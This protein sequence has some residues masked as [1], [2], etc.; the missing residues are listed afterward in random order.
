MPNKP[1]GL[2]VPL[3]KGDVYVVN[4]DPTVGAETR[5]LRPA[6][7]IQ[8]NVGNQYSPV[9]T[10]APVSNAKLLAKPIPVLVFLR[11]GEGGLKQDSY[12]HCEQIR[13]VDKSRLL[14]KCGSLPASRISEVNQAI[15]ISTAYLSVPH[16]SCKRGTHHETVQPP[17]S[18]P[19]IY[20][21]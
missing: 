15:K 14:E 8:N 9:T 2:V 7:I 3:L 1:S 17:G 13:T 20:R 12:V 5:K 4:L 19:H 11:A 10:V 18:K 6:V 16:F 21:R